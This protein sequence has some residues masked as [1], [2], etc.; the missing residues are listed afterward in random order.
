MMTLKTGVAYSEYT[1]AAFSQSTEQPQKQ[2]SPAYH[3]AARSLDPGLYSQPCSPGPVKSELNTYNT[4]KVLGLVAG[5]YAGLSSAFH[6]ITDLIAFQLA[7]EH[8]KLFDIYH[9]TC[10]SIALQQ[11]RR[12]LGLALLLAKGAS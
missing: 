12:S 2:V 10:K 4:G 11:A 9:G 5:A 1:S 6:V 7:D 8:P 3:A